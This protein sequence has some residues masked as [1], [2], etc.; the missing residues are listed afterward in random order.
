M[1][2]FIYA[3][4]IAGYL[5]LAVSAFNLLLRKK[6]KTNN[7]T[8]SDDATGNSADKCIVLRSERD[9]KI[10]PITGELRGYHRE[11][12]E[13]LDGLYDLITSPA[14]PALQLSIKDDNDD[15]V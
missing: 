7:D 6:S 1:F 3:L 15:R 13:R 10:S 5:S 8:I 4:T 9:L 11:L 12:M 2:D 14:K